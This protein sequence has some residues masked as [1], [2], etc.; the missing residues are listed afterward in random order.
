MGQTGL[1]GLWTRLSYKQIVQKIV[2]KRLIMRSVIHAINVPV[3]LAKCV[4]YLIVVLLRIPNP[5]PNPRILPESVR[6]RIRE[7][8][9]AVSDSF[10][11]SVCESIFTYQV[12]AFKQHVWPPVPPC[13]RLNGC[14]AA[15]PP[16]AVWSVTSAVTS[17]ISH[18][19][20]II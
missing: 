18:L 8:F 9:V 17:R 7:S 2:Y 16:P 10:G 3:T 12:T 1:R 5:Q 15:A 20:I 13:G 11:S 6:V 14:V 19:Q 4:H